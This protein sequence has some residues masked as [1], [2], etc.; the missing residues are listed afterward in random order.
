MICGKANT[1]FG[2]DKFTVHRV[3]YF[4]KLWCCRELLNRPKFYIIAVEDCLNWRKILVIEYWLSSSG[5]DL[6]NT[7]INRFVLS[8]VRNIIQRTKLPIQ[9]LVT[10][11]ISWQRKEVH[12]RVELV[13]WTIKF[14]RNLFT[15]CPV[16]RI[17]WIG[18]N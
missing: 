1:H 17:Q 18:F 7:M 3:F 15:F 11:E 10:T 12:L 14:M 2:S 6:Q 13:I 16:T 9:V 4:R 8:V 5:E